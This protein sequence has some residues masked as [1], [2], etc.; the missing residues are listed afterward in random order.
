M[1]QGLLIGFAGAI[2]GPIL[3]LVF[4]KLGVVETVEIDPPFIT[5]AILAGA[6][7]APLSCVIATAFRR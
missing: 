2:M 6:I 1:K 5:V 3:L 7:L 4:M